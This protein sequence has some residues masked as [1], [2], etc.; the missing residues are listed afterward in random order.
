MDLLILI[1]VFGELTVCRIQKETVH[2]NVN[3]IFQFMAQMIDV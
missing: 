3:M 2:L 1:Q